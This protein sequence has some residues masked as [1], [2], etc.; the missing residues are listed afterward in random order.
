MDIQ[1]ELLSK[2]KLDVKNTIR[3]TEMYNVLFN[4]RSTELN[5]LIEMLGTQLAIDLMDI[6]NVGNEK[7]TIYI[8]HFAYA[9]ADEIGS[10]YV[11]MQNLSTKV[12]VDEAY[13]ILNNTALIQQRKSKFEKYNNELS[14]WQKKLKEFLIGATRKGAIG[15]TLYLAGPEPFGFILKMVDNNKFACEYKYFNQLESMI[16]LKELPFELNCSSE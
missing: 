3:A 2:L 9:V 13:N 6:G 4:K 11:N 1:K 5:D 14:N 7:I 8:T 15:Q 16:D 10:H 12:F